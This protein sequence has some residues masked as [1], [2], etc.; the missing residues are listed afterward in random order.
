MKKRVQRMP[1]ASRNPRRKSGFSLLELTIVLMVMISL[2]AIVWPNLQRP[3][4]RTSL[5]EAAQTL[6][7]AI[8]ESRYQAITT[9]SPV[10]VQLRPGEGRIRSG[11]FDSFMNAQSDSLSLAGD[12]HGSTTVG[13]EAILSQRGSSQVSS[14]TQLAIRTWQLPDSVVIS[15]VRW[16]LEAPAS[17][18]SDSELAGTELS[19][20]GLSG[21]G[22]AKGYLRDS[23]ASTQSAPLATADLPADATT[24]AAWG[25]STN[26]WWLP[27][28][29]TG[30]GR[31]A[32]I[33]LL[34]T[35]INEVLTVT[36]A[37]A[38]GALEIVR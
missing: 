38:T 28:V 1:M 17:E 33:V 2:L 30:Q 6:R 24:A 35:S 9:G 3:L 4:R 22:N 37:S 18:F 23:A 34:D 31:D 19:D 10:F 12:S 14:A 16:T 13:S 11:S 29:A 25:Q 27:L 5:S 15:E 20:S 26:D 8:D 7:S 32:A 21:D 36:F